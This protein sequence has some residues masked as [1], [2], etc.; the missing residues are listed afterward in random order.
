[1]EEKRENAFVL[2]N[3]LVNYFNSFRYV[4]KKSYLLY[5]ILSNI[6]DID[7]SL[8]CFSRS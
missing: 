8:I 7:L 6:L 5:C 2:L 1:M 3:K 4:Y